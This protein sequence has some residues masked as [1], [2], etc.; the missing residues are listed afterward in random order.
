MIFK[1]KARLDDKISLLPFEKQI[2][3]GFSRE[4]AQILGWHITKFKTQEQWKYATG[5]DCIVAVIDTGCDME[6]PDLKQNLLPGANVIDLNKSPQDDNGHGSHVCGTIAGINNDL[7]I[8]GV[9]PDTKIFPIKTLDAKGNCTLANLLS[10]VE[11]AIKENVDFITMSLGS[12]KPSEELQKLLKEA[13]KRGIIC[14]CAAG[15]SGENADVTYPA[16]YDSVISIGAIDEELERTDFTCS[17]DSLDFLAPGHNI[18]STVQNG[19]ATMSGTSMSNPVA[20]GYACLLA[21]FNK[22]VKKFTLKNVDD[23]IN[24]FQ[25]QAVSLTNQK[26]KTKKYQGYGIINLDLSLI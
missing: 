2:L 5:K 15:N 3:Y 18:I 25:K 1:R 14:F 20:V 19:Y 23:Y 6:H 9:A 24:I 21:D 16:K 10:A 12:P 17:G 4:S 11:L 7:G 22:R 13:N 26:Y 8:V